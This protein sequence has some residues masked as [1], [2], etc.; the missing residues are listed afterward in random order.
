MNNKQELRKNWVL[1]S[2]KEVEGRYFG[3]PTLFIATVPPGFKYDEFTKFVGR[4]P[5]VF[6]G[7]GCFHPGISIKT[8]ALVQ[9][10]LDH[11]KLV[12]LEVRPPHLRN[13]P[14]HHLQLC[15]LMVSLDIPELQLLKETDTVRL[16]KQPFDGYCFTL[17]TGMVSNPPMY[18]HDRPLMVL[19]ELGHEK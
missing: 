4:F 1:F 8:G 18:D 9:F 14:A 17:S 11:K 5:H 16:L 2:G 6:F 7:V 13:I 15:H 3:I 12:T 10:C 19:G